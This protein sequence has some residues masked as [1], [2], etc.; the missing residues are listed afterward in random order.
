MTLVWDS[1]LASQ[2]HW[3]A[4]AL[5]MDLQRTAHQSAYTRTQVMFEALLS[6]LEEE[7]RI[8][9]AWVCSQDFCFC[10]PLD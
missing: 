1:F 3:Q 6:V 7:K 10:F 8:L 5:S 9:G 4:P 2:R